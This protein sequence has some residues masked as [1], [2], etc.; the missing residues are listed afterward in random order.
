MRTLILLVAG[1]ALVSCTTA[2]PMT[3]A[4]SQQRVAALLAGKVAGPPVDCIPH[5]QTNATAVITPNAIAF[6]VSRSQVYVTSTVGSGCEGLS[7]PMY[8][9]TS[10]SN[11]PGGLCRG[12]IVKVIDPQTRMMVGSC[13]LAAFVPYTRP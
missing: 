2:P 11:G 10:T 12:D 13:S 7:N 4:T 1:A 9:L 8:T 3:D 5:Y 6:D